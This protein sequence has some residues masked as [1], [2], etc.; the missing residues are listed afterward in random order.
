MKVWGTPKLIQKLK[1]I[2][3]YSRIV[4]ISY[5]TLTT[6]RIQIKIP[7]FC[8][9]E[10]GMYVSDFI[11]LAQHSADVMFDEKTL[12]YSYEVCCE[13]KTVV[14]KE[15]KLITANYS[16]PD[17]EAQLSIR[18]DLLPILS[19][20]NTRMCCDEK[21]LILESKG[22]MPSRAVVDFTRVE[23]AGTVSC[24]VRPKSLKMINE[25]DGEKVLCFCSNFIVGYGIEP[26]T[27]T[28]ILINHI[29]CV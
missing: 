27:T 24:F 4:H 25:I 22:Y 1:F 10:C 17:V 14:Y 15:C 29:D 8:D 20:D 5:D 18:I 19:E 23:G 12:K 26:D 7:R 6:E 28:A 13:P 2:Q 16:F 11:E 21:Q 9:F 3:K